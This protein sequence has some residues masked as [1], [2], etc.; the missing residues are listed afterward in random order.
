MADQIESEIARL[1]SAGRR[2]A[3][4]GIRVEATNMEA[5]SLRAGEETWLGPTADTFTVHLSASR[6]PAAHAASRSLRHVVS[7]VDD[8]VRRLREEQ[9]RAGLRS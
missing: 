3:D 2:L 9:L 5:V 6:T 4:L 1:R 8:Q 7:L